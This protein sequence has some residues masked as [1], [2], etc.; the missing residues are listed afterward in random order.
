MIAGVI[1]LPES[2]DFLFAKGRFEESK[3]VLLR[4]AKFNGREVDAEQL[5]FGSKNDDNQDHSPT[6]TNMHYKSTKSYQPSEFKSH[7]VNSQHHHYY[8]T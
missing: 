5:K 7:A 3:E 8:T 2:P 6:E 4:I 1:W